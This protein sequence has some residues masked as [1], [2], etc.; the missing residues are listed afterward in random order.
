MQTTYPTAAG[1]FYACN[2]EILTGLESEGATPTFTADTITIIYAMNL[3]T[4]IPPAGTKLVVHSA[5]GRWM[6]RYDG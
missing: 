5:G 2:P 4:Q 1:Q 6:F 3:G